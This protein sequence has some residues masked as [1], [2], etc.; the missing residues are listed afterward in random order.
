VW[1]SFTERNSNFVWQSRLSFSR[2]SAL[3]TTLEKPRHHFHPTPVSLSRL[4]HKPI[5][6]L[7]EDRFEFAKA[8]NLEMRLLFALA[9]VTA[10]FGQTYT[11][12]RWIH[13]T[14]R[15]C[16]MGAN[17]T[18]YALGKCLPEREGG[19]A[20]EYHC[21]ADGRAAF[22]QEYA[23][24]TCTRIA[25]DPRRII[26][27]QCVSLG[28]VGSFHA[29]CVSAEPEPVPEVAYTTI[30]FSHYTDRACSQGLNATVV[31]LDKCLPEREPNR[32]RKVAC[33]DDGKSATDTEYA[34]GQCGRAI[35]MPFHIRTDECIHLGDR[36]SFNAKC[37]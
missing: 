6:F 13:Y 30:T 18:T 14:D 27:G 26:T 24:N 17:T 8:L 3:V 10:V 37:S 2:S 7:I 36:G 20:R 11:G 15:G 19:R 33:A 1:N 28:T 5:Q 4:H 23:D 34:D 16:T 25:G 9:L 32:S 29:Q 31:A 22:D 21:S 12:L 35:G